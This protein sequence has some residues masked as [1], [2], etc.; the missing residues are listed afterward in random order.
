MAETLMISLTQTPFKLQ[1]N[2]KINQFKLINN[3]TEIKLDAITIN[4]A[5]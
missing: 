5:K 2:T 3:K 4:E 1:N